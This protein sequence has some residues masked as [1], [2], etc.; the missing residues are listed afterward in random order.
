MFVEVGLL[1]LTFVKAGLLPFRA[2]S[3]LLPGLRDLRTKK[4]NT[5]GVLYEQDCKKQPFLCPFSP[6]DLGGPC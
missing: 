2:D 4:K 6:F 3:L 5:H 1:T